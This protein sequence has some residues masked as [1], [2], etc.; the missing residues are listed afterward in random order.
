MTP[1][2]HQP[3]A[4]RTGVLPRRRV[5]LVLMYHRVASVSHDPH[6]LAVSPGRFAWQMAWLNRRRLRGVAVAELVDAMR[7]G[8]A[9]GLVG[10][11]FDDAY[12]DLIDP[13]PAVLRRYGFSAT[14]FVVSGRLGGFNDW[15]RDTPWPL[16]DGD[17]VRRLA[18]AGLEIGSH[19]RTHAA[20]AATDPA[21]LR[22][23]TY[24]SRLD[25]ETLVGAPIR[26]FAYPYGSMDAAA[27]EAVRAAGY[28][29]GCAVFAPRP[30]QSLMALPRIY[31]GERDAGIRLTAKRALYRWHVSKR[32]GS[33]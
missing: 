18:D 9:D 12:A 4:T 10:I 13:V 32:G 3:S 20:L 24:G 8:T 19:G 21:V 22:E 28:A 5:P 16:V 27:R 25:L 6:A 11:T 15:D 1:H 31:I 30:D 7:A 26:G 17:G 14:V 29:Y 33:A 23:E 2:L